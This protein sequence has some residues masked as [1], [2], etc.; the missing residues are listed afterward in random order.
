MTN[1][2]LFC[3]T[4]SIAA[5]KA[6]F[7][8]RE[9]KAKGFLVT[10]IITEAAKKFITPFTLELLSDGNCYEE[11]DF[12]SQNNLHITLAQTHDTLLIAPATANTIA[13]CAAGIAD[14]LMLNCFLAFEGKK[15]IVPAMHTE[16]INNKIVQANIARCKQ[17]NCLV[18]GPIYGEL[19]SDDH[20][21]GRMVEPTEIATCLTKLKFNNI[22]LSKKNILIT[23]GG[24]TEKID[25]VR[26]LSNQSS[27]EMGL[28][29]AR[30]AY[31]NG[32][33][34]TLISTKKNNDIG[35]QRIIQVN[36]SEELQSAIKESILDNDTL[37]MAAAV[38]DYLP[39]YNDKKLKRDNNTQIPIK[40]NRDILKDIT[41]TYDIDTVVGFC[42]Q[43]DI[44]DSELP[45]KKSAKKHCDFMIAND[46][47]NIGSKKRTYKI[48]N[49]KECIDEFNDISIHEAAYRILS[50]TVHNSN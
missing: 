47:S 36:N 4:G 32:A 17:N 10:C 21:Y 13:K 16:M 39:V 25:P 45:L 9:L 43:D 38:S 5:I 35:Y 50:K 27:G 42:L 15:V 29:L 19:L 30:L 26:T 8:I 24:T 44:Q 41:Q 40:K 33:N 7:I 12:W 37:I 46:S 1:R 20:G 2:I 34:V 22:D 28:S 48:Y 14:N 49:K 18:L 31:I 6:P 3:I 11:K 23:A